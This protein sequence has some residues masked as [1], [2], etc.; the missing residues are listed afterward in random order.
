MLRPSGCPRV[1]QHCPDLRHVVVQTRSGDHRARSKRTEPGCFGRRSSRC[2][3]KWGWHLSPLTH[4]ATSGGEFPPFRVAVATLCPFLLPPIRRHRSVIRNCVS[5]S[6]PYPI[7]LYGPT[8]DR[9]HSCVFLFLHPVLSPSLRRS[10]IYHHH[11]PPVSSPLLPDFVALSLVFS[12]SFSFSFHDG[13]IVAWISDRCNNLL[14]FSRGAESLR[15][16][17]LKFFDD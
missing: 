10:S 1:L 13:T 4:G 6:S 3:T 5:L 17:G 14:V 12:F 9:T 7:W 16:S 11:C 2:G 8:N 15:D